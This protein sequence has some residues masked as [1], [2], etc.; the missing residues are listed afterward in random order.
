LLT[1]FDVT[2][3]RQDVARLAAG[4]PVTS[5]LLDFALIDVTGDD[6]VEFLHG[7]VTADLKTLPLSR[8]ATAA[9]C[10]PKGRV[11]ATFAALRVLSGFRLLLPRAVAASFSKRLSMYVL[12]SKVTV[13]DATAGV[14]LVGVG[15]DSAAARGEEKYESFAL[16]PR[17][18]VAIV[19][20]DDA[21]AVT[22]AFGARGLHAV[23][24]AAWAWF[25]VACGFPW[26]DPRTQD[27]FTPHMLN[28]DLTGGVS[29]QK[30]CYP[31]Q[32][33]V[34]RT[35]YLGQVKRRLVRIQAD[36]DTA[37]EPGDPLYAAD[38]GE[39]TAGTVVQAVPSPAHGWEM[40]AVLQRATA[41]AAAVTLGA[42]AGP[43]VRALPLP[44]PVP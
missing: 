14:V 9:Y 3:V 28:L 15:N 10:T 33:I 2:A 17:H 30:G 35:Q 18:R 1:D 31:G 11:L 8:T 29:F 23:S 21:P 41:A 7:Q 13:R 16:S 42:A 39:Q 19:P 24:S 38:L 43:V 27:A 32:E 5:T 6:A 44:Y 12:R 25:D 4:E 20:A 26:I 22:A 36:V 34:A 40:L 37:P